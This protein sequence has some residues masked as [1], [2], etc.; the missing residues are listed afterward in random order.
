[1]LHA[2]HTCW[3]GE[4]KTLLMMWVHLILDTV[5]TENEQTYN[6]TL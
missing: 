5:C 4:V 2:L 6:D 3:L 1:M